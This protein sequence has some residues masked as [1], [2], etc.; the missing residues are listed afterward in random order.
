MDYLGSPNPH[1][2]IMA[3]MTEISGQT[4]PKTNLGP[5][6]QQQQRRSVTG[7]DAAMDGK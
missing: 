4:G 2:P 5:P 3:E 7:Y 1:V 6:Q